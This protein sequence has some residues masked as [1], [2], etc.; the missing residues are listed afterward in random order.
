MCSKNETGKASK[1]P[2]KDDFI[3]EHGKKRATD[4][5]CKR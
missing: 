3:D 5:R 1:C 2:H 4:A